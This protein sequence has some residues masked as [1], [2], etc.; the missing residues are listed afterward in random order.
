MLR[1]AHA[2]TKMFDFLLHNRLLKLSIL[3][4]TANF[5]IHMLCFRVGDGVV[6]TGTS[7]NP[8]VFEVETPVLLVYLLSAVLLSCLLLL[9][10]LCKRDLRRVAILWHV[11]SGLIANLLT[12]LVV[13]PYILLSFHKL[14]VGIRLCG[15]VLFIRSLSE[16]LVPFTLISISID[17][18]ASLHY[19]DFYDSAKRRFAI[20]LISLSWISATTCSVVMTF[21]VGD[22]AVKAGSCFAAPWTWLVDLL[23]RCAVPMTA[24]IL[25][26]LGVVSASLCAVAANPGH[27]HSARRDVI[28][29]LVP[30]L[31]YV[32]VCAPYHVAAAVGPADGATYRYLALYAQ[33]WPALLP[34]LWT[35]V[36]ADIRASLWDACCC[37]SKSG[38]DEYLRLIR[39]APP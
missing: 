21:A 30:T 12:G 7:S 26:A 13:Y 11:I 33:C 2:S 22:L 15:F 25:A 10:L 6:T 32:C 37:R 4:I 36:M 35:L 14:A 31:G 28:G 17:R 34:L 19:P 9:L 23:A 3:L 1:Q 16:V 5:V 29:I 27:A 8:D 24:A 39:A 38:D 18:I 20:L